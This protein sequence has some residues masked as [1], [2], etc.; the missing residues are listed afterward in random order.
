[1]KIRWRQMGE[2]LV[3]LVGETIV[4][5]VTESPPGSG[6]WFAYGCLLEW[7][8]TRQGC[9]PDEMEARLAIEAWAEENAEP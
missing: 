3:A 5:T 8:D 2:G 4:G 7:E 9:F 1:M 6:D